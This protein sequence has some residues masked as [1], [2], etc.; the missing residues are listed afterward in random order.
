MLGGHPIDS[1]EGQLG[2]TGLRVAIPAPPSFC[3]SATG[4]GWD[5]GRAYVSAG[6]LCTRR[7]PS[8]ADTASPAHRNNSRHA[9][10][11]RSSHPTTHATCMRTHVLCTR[12]RTRTH[13]R[14]LQRATVPFHRNTSTH[15]HPASARTP[16][17]AHTHADTHPRLAYGMLFHLDTNNRTQPTQAS[18]ISFAPHEGDTHT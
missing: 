1:I 6:A 18:S 9:L 15:G 11:L 12:T 13:A 10:S 17:H 14:V 2:R 8:T 5:G 16:T 3:A 4:S 7:Y